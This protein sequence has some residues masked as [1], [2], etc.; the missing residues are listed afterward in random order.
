MS[1]IALQTATTLVASSTAEDPMMGLK[2]VILFG[3]LLLMP[4]FF[5]L[6]C[7]GTYKWL[8][9]VEKFGIKEDITKS[10]RRRR[11]EQEVAQEMLAKRM[12][13]RGGT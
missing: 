7:V 12:K 5:V 3:S 9:W 2:L 1:P 11:L 10:M 13:R 6:V 8:R 4:V